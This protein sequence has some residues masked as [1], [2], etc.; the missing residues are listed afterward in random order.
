MA[1]DKLDEKLN[2]A[3]KRFGETG[4]DRKRFWRKWKIKVVRKKA[5]AE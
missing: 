3:L 4:A 5:E 2:A 1:R